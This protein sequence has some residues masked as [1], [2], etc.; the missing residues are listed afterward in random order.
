MI[1]E[2]KKTYNLDINIF[3][4]EYNNT[5]QNINEIINNTPKK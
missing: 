5:T 1:I 4:I 2:Y 3:N